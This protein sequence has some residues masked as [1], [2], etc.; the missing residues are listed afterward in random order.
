MVFAVDEGPAFLCGDVRFAVDTSV[1][2]AAVGA[3]VAD[4][5]AMICSDFYGGAVG[6]GITKLPT[7]R[8]SCGI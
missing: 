5:S 4:P 1:V 8:K 2:I 3:D 7:T 6:G